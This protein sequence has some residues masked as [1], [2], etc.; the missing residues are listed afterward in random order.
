MM[1]WAQWGRGRLGDEAGHVGGLG[2]EKL[3]SDEVVL[4]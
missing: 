3:S 1:S 2:C 4:A